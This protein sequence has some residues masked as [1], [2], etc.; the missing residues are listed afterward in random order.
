[1][2]EIIDDGNYTMAHPTKILGEPCP[3]RPTLERPRWT[4]SVAG[5]SNVNLI[6]RGGN[7]GGVGSFQGRLCWDVM[8]VTLRPSACASAARLHI[9]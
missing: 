8:Y 7:S 2:A 5:R 9:K 4:R 3:A 6:S 1:M